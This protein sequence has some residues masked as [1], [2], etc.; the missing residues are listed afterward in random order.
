LINTQ[1]RE[2]NKDKQ[3]DNKKNDEDNTED[4]GFQQLKGTVAVIFSGVSVSRS[5]HQDK[6]A[7]HSIVAAEPAVPRYLNWS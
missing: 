3:E 6:L 4:K 5:K 2:K 1:E 7:L